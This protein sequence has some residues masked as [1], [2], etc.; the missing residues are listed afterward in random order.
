MLVEGSCILLRLKSRRVK[1]GSHHPAFMG[2]YPTISHT[3]L[4]L[5]AQWM[6]SPNEMRT[7]GQS[8][9]SSFCFCVRCESTK[10]GGRGNSRFPCVTPVVKT[11]L[12]R[13]SH[14][15]FRQTSTTKL[16]CKKSQRA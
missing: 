9:S 2:N 13:V 3:F 15:E 12:D 11:S 1:G 10:L 4:V 14:L 7:W 6:S 5:S 16:L 8:K